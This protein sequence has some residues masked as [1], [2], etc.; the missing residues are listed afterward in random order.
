MVMAALS[1]LSIT[2]FHLPRLASAGR[3]LES[4]RSVR[5]YWHILSRTTLGEHGSPDWAHVSAV[6][7][8]ERLGEEVTQHVEIETIGHFKFLERDQRERPE[9]ETRERDQ[10]ERDQRERD[11]RERPERERPETSVYSLTKYGQQCGPT[12]SP[13]RKSGWLSFFLFGQVLRDFSLFLFA[14]I[15]TVDTLPLIWPWASRAISSVW[16]Q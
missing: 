2:S 9:R 1:S 16:G 7:P 5:G 8:L 6:I 11:Q 3:Y 12:D 13:P 10:R 4:S 14:F 15:V